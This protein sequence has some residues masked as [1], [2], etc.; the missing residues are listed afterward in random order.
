MAAG[1]Y[2]WSFST[3]GGVKRVNLE[4]GHDLVNLPSLD[5]KL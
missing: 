4:S 1:N 3:V 5:Q 2:Q